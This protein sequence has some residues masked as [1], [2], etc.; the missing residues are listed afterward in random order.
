MKKLIFLIV[1]LGA[2]CFVPVVSYAA[3][4]SGA[5]SWHEGVDCNA[6][7]DLDGSAICTD[8]WKDSSVSFLN[9]CEKE[10]SLMKRIE[11]VASGLCI[12]EFIQSHPGVSATGN[13]SSCIED[14]TFSFYKAYDPACKKNMFLSSNGRCFCLGYLN[15]GVCLSDVFINDVYIQYCGGSK[16]QTSTVLD[17]MSSS[18]D[19]GNIFLISL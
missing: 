9:V 17:I 3:T 11:S 6:G 10:L 4:G 18:I 7:A 14:K 5:C 12:N 1:V 19:H 8:G 2:I 15:S 16:L 13:I